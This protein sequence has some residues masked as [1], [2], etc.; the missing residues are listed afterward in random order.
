MVFTGILGELPCRFSCFFHTG[1]CIKGNYEG[2]NAL[3]TPRKILVIAQ[4]TFAIVLIIGTVIVRQQI[5]Y[6]QDRETG[7]DKDHLVYHFTEGK[8]QRITT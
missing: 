8:Q 3:V 2:A 4:F 5:H 7:Y 1:K 6:A